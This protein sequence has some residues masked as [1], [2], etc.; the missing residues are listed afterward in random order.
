MR[1]PVHPFSPITKLVDYFFIRQ[2]VVVLL[3]LDDL[4]T[5]SENTLEVKGKYLPGFSSIQ[6]SIDRYLINR[7][8]NVT[9]SASSVK[10]AVY[11]SF[12]LND[13]V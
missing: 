3:S 12:S 13:K 1:I 10:N 9:R 6:M 7:K 4:L 2:V 11:N 5:Q 8:R